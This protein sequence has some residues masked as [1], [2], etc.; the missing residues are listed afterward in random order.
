MPLGTGSVLSDLSQTIWF[1]CQKA[2]HTTQAKKSN[3]G[4]SQQ[5][6]K[7]S[8]EALPSKLVKVNSGLHSQT[9]PIHGPCTKRPWFINR[10]TEE[11]QG[12]QLPRVN[13]P[14]KLAFSQ[15]VPKGL[16]FHIYP[17]KTRTR[18]NG[19]KTVGKA[20]SQSYRKWLQWYNRLT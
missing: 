14:H 4:S 6:T 9:I 15:W 17:T 3:K 13:A 18:G 20:M 19:L 8:A 7:P 1:P 12:P 16:L 11:K 5:E 2:H 10:T